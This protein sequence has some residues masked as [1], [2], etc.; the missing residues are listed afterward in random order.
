VAPLGDQPASMDDSDARDRYR[1]QIARLLGFPGVGALPA[2][3][4]ASNLGVPPGALDTVLQ[5]LAEEGRVA[6]TDDGYVALPARDS[7]Q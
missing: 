4:I 7:G 3:A 5:A 2:G 6:R 1:Q